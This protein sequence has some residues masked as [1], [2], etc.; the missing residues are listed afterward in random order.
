[1][2]NS[3]TY[4]AVILGDDP[5]NPRKNNMSTY[6]NCFEGIH[7]LSQKTIYELSSFTPI[8]PFSNWRSNKPPEWWIN[9]TA[10]KHNRFKNQDR[11]TLK[12]VLDALGALF[13]LNAIVPD[14]KKVLIKNGC[15]HSHNN[16][17]DLVN[18]IHLLKTDEPLKT[19]AIIYV[20]TD[21]FGYVYENESIKL[22][23]DAK[24]Q[25]L[26]PWLSGYYG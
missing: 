11:A 25:I 19:S 8:T 2:F 6:R 7:H 3:G 23:E 17:A 22:V 9:Y 20:K 21:L 1:M 15:V 14:T 10:I 18:I 4:C 16:T 5:K 24:R 12:T 26:S 13:L